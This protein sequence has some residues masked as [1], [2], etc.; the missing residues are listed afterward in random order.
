VSGSE[1]RFRRLDPPKRRNGDLFE[2][3]GVPIEAPV[4]GSVDQLLTR[5]VRACPACGWFCDPE[6]A[7]DNCGDEVGPT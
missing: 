2:H 7:C 5:I 3:F 4:A 1:D 6:T